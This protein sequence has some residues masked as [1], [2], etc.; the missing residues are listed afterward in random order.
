[1]AIAHRLKHLEGKFLILLCLWSLLVLCLCGCG[2]RFGQGTIPSTYR[3]ISVPYICG[4]EE[5][6]LTAAVI[7]EFEQSGGLRVV[8]SGAQLLAQINLI[9]LS[10][11]NIGFRYDRKNGGRL[12]HHV[13]PTETRMIATARFSVVDVCSSKTILG[14]VIL[15][16]N[17][18]FDHDYYTSRNGVNVFSLGQLNDIDA[19]RSAVIVPLSRVLA[20]KIVEYVNE[21]W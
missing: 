10:D 19:A 21:S 2:Y 4:D 18:D 11:E 12:T 5:G 16:A 9:D 3:T 20:R 14:P 13:I 15:S 6:I 7:R 8:D 17:V 1:M